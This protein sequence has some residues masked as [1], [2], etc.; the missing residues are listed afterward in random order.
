MNGCGHTEGHEDENET[1]TEDDFSPPH[2]RRE[3]A[4]A[5]Q[6]MFMRDV[7]NTWFS[8]S[9]I[10]ENRSTKWRRKKLYM[11]SDTR[12]TKNKNRI[13]KS[14][15]WKDIGTETDKLINIIGTRFRCGVTAPS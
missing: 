11:T 8:A 7:T 13:K 1:E 6:R 12:C 9:K 15:I 5:N 2:P 4:S 14:D 3:N 10:R